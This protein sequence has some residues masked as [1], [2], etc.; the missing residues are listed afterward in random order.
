MKD[1]GTFYFGPDGVTFTPG[2]G[3]EDDIQDNNEQL[4]SAYPAIEAKPM[5]I[6]PTLASL[7]TR[8]IQ[9]ESELQELKEMV[10]KLLSL[11]ESA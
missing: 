3:Y 11:N 9:V 4:A 5:P 8:L 7:E 10:R 1:F 2:D 6:F